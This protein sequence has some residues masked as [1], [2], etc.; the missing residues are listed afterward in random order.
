MTEADTSVPAN[1][2]KSLLLIL[3]LILAVVGG[4]YAWYWLTAGQFRETTDDAYV[5]GNLVEITPRSEGTVVSIHAE[6]MDPVRQGET[7]V[8]LDD[9]G[10]RADLDQAKAALAETVRQT[11]QLLAQAKQQ[12]AVVTL[13]ERE[14]AL[15]KDTERRR[16]A[17]AD[18]KLAPEEQAQQ[19]KL[20]TEIAAANLEV[21]RR[22]L[23]TT[24]AL[25]QN[26][27]LARQP[28]V[29]NAE[30]HL[31]NAYLDWGFPRR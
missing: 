8:T 14:L 25:I 7:L 15:M 4:S 10:A 6:E 13:R 21:A 26:T 30:A 11:A 29:L 31:R 22:Q 18:Q 2:R 3:L 28:A 19:S 20:S 23:I 16:V 12:R 24:E 27:P 17:L 5:G 9:S 1:Q